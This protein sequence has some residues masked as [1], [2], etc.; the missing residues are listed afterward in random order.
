MTLETL[1]LETKGKSRDFILR[2]IGSHWRALNKRVK[3]YIYIL[4]PLEAESEWD[5]ARMGRPAES[6]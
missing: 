2:A 4:I 5:G 1:G 6:C 3:G